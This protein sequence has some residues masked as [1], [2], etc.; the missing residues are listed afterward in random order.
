MGQSYSHFN[1]WAV[2]TIIFA[3]EADLERVIKVFE[4][5]RT[6]DVIDL[7]QTVNICY[8]V[9]EKDFLQLLRDEG[10]HPSDRDFLLNLFR[11]IDSR[12]FGE[13]DIRDAFVCFSLLVV[14]SIPRVFELSINMLEREG[15]NIVDKQQLFHVIRLLN[16]T[17]YY[18][19]DRYLQS[20]Q[21]HD[22]V[23]S[24]YTSAGKI[25]GTVYFPHFVE[26][27]ANHPIV[28]MFLSPQFQGSA[29]DK[30]MDEKQIEEFVKHN[31]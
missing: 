27:L 2:S 6:C 8:V 19:G 11:L 21:L 12:G 29:R 1:V 18:F 24:L 5:S 13:I 23:D 28:E 3:T 9:K 22:L 17:C 14:K 15:T 7:H 25:D 20:E 26:F 30:L 16:D 10:F 4:K 31:K